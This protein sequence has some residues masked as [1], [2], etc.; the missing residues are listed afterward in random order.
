MLQRVIDQDRQAPAADTGAPP[1]VRQLRELNLERSFL[2]LWLNPRA[3]EPDLVQKVKNAKGPDAAFLANFLNYW[4]ALDGLALF[5]A[6]GESLEL[7][8]AVKART[9]ALP[10]AARRVL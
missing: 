3:F 5:V 10:G 9:A 4:K 6:P 2:A 7:G 8:V 1:L